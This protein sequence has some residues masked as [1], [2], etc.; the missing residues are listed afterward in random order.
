M[1]L[2]RLLLVED[3]ADMAAMMAAYLRRQGLHVTLADSRAGALAALKSGRVDLILLDVSLGRDDG[4][5]LCAEIR[6][7]QDVPI[8]MVS[9]LSADHQRMAG[10]AV[11]ADDYI[12]KPF[13]PD[14]LLA[15]IRAVL[16]RAGRAPSLIHR[17]RDS[18]LRFGGWRYDARRDEVTAPGGWQVT[19][20][21]RET[22][23]L[24]VFLANPLIPLTREEIAAA[25]DDDEAAEGR[26]IDMLVGRL[27]Q[28]TDAS[29][30]RTERGVGYVLAA[31]V[32][33]AD[34]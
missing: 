2:H 9:A 24:R 14:L 25:L 20:S 29:L 30:I 26:A 21:A 32:T 3:D 10:Y 31:D 12:A 11:G 16:R 28:K 17:R 5:A 19:L 23:L 33:R 4:V 8:I 18:V 22:A 15:R 1:S 6:A 13:N 7:A 27:R 34:D